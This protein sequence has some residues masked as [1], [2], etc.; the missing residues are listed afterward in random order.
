MLASVTGQHPI[1]SI[2]RLPS[3]FYCQNTCQHMLRYTNTQ[4]LQYLILQVQLFSHTT[5]VAYLSSV[6]QSIQPS[7]KETVA[8]PFSFIDCWSAGTHLELGLR[9]HKDNNSKIFGRV[10][11]IQQRYLLCYLWNVT[12]GAMARSLPESPKRTLPHILW[13]RAKVSLETIPVF[14][15]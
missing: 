15:W 1:T 7:Q 11:T 10:W 9:L 4:C 5:D 6:W 8:G 2:H 12:F 13:I 3:E 14:V